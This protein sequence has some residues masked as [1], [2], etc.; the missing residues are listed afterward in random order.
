MLKS[1]LLGHINADTR[2]WSDGVLTLKAQE[3]YNEPEGNF[4]LR[5]LL[6]S[7]NFSILFFF[8]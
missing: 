1:Q 6:T 4:Y 2:Q 3:V 5:D 8:T 7:E